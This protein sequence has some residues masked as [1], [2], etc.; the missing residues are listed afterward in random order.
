MPKNLRKATKEI[1]GSGTSFISGVLNEDHNRKFRNISDS[2]KEYE[3]VLRTD[4]TA[5]ATSK[6][7][8]LPITNATFFWE[9]DENAERSEE[10][11]DGLREQFFDRLNFTSLM[12]DILTCIDYG[13]S[14]FEVVWEIKEGRAWIKK[15]AM[16]LPKSI[17]RWLPDENGNVGIEQVYTDLNGTHTVQIPGENL[18]RVTFNQVGDNWAGESLFRS[19]YINHEMKIGTYKIQAI[20]VERSGIGVPIL[21]EGPNALSGEQRAAAQKVLADFGTTEGAHLIIPHGA[22]F[23]L[24]TTPGDTNLPFVITHHDRQISKAAL[25]QF[26]DHGAGTNHGALSQSQSDMGIF[27][28]SA[29]AIA[30]MIADCIEKGPARDFVDYNYGP[31][32]KVPHLKIKN[33]EKDD[34]E[35][36][37]QSISGLVQSG[38]LTMDAKTENFLRNTFGLPEIEETDREDIR[39]E[40]KQPAFQPGPKEEDKELTNKKKGIEL[41]KKKLAHRDLTMAE[42]RMDIIKLNQ[43]LDKT[44][45]SLKKKVKKYETFLRKDLSDRARE[46]YDSGKFPGRSNEFTEKRNEMRE[47][48]KKEYLDIYEFGKTEA[49]REMGLGGRTSTP[50]EDRA[51][52]VLGAQTVADEFFNNIEDKAKLAASEAIRTKGASKSVVVAAIAT[53][54]TDTAKVK[55]GTFPQLGSLSAFNMGLDATYGANEEQIWGYQYSAVLDANTTDICL[56]LDGRV[57]R[58][59]KE[60]PTPP[61]HVNC[62]SRIIAVLNEQAEKPPVNKPPK[63]VMENVSPD[64]FKTK[65]IGKVI[66]S[67]NSPGVN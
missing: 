13:V 19:A 47:E 61:V 58:K 16:R 11:V 12:K 5:V 60:L 67:P 20:G 66:Q 3:K 42:E 21:K 25:A 4:S 14:V 37:A 26:I 57:T 51:A 49:V 62:R 65:N 7:V 6:M 30:R 33:I 2:A 54:V 34:L 10:I 36:M 15:F 44:E 22:D 31:Q 27:L 23:M 1:G 18:F 24:P 43:K 59:R 35:K 46:F 56:S 28:T 40:S 48:V 50:K 64:P 53:V 55:F 17:R 41:S 29:M 45:E 8:K 9:V 63:E 39:K 52:I 38:A 32:Y